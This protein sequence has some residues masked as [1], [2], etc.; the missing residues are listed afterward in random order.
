MKEKIGANDDVSFYVKK[1]ANHMERY[2]HTRYS[3]KELEEY[4][5]MNMW[6]VDF[7]F[8]QKGKDTFQKDVEAEFFISP[9]TA[10]K[11]LNL[12]EEKSLIKRTSLPEDG[13]LKKLELQP[14]GRKLQV[15]CKAIRQDME[16]KVTSHLTE[17]E[18]A[19]FKSLCRKM[20]HSME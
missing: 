18:T 4:S 20:I 6:V 13:R 5:L 9:S 19:Q 11:M 12:M 7:L 15:I 14:K 17:E 2:A 10:S 1:L 16:E 3:R 8:N